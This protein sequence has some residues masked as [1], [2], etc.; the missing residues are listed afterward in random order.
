MTVSKRHC[1]LVLALVVPITF[2]GAHPAQRL[3]DR[4]DDSITRQRITDDFTKAMLVAKD[5]Y[6]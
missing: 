5:N 6:A 4:D 3:G 2:A 1:L